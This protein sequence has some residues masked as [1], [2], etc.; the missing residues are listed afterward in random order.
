MSA[1]PVS[2]VTAAMAQDH[3]PRVHR[4][5]VMVS[6]QGTDPEDLAQQAMLR[7]I[8]CLGQ[9]DPHRG[10]LDAWLWRIVV[11]LARDMGQVPRRRELLIERPPVRSG[12]R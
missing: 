11:N 7:A 3:L 6:P 1:A 5:A 12:V 4:F 9:H 8:E 10:N 2:A